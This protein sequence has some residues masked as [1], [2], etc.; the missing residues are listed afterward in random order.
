MGKREKRR[1]GG[2]LP[3]G[4]DPS[5]FVRS[6]RD[7][8][9]E[10]KTRQLCREVRDVLSLALST[11]DDEALEGAWVADV[12]PG[13]DA[14]QLRVIVIAP[15]RSDPD[16]AYDALR[17]AASLLRAEMAQAIARKRTPQ[18]TF[19]LHKEDAP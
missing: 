1:A 10:R 9:A 4:I 18:L 13:A 14:S 2:P 12:L 19:E 16:A 5:G 15:G 6:T 8:R 17:R 11:L 3:G 7:H